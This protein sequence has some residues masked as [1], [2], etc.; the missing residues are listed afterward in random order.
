VVA[1]C[2]EDPR[3]KSRE[4]SH[5]APRTLA[6]V[7]SDHVAFK[8]ECIDRVY[9]NVYVPQLQH[10]GEGR[11]EHRDAL[12][13]MNEWAASNTTLCT[14]G[15]ILREYLAVA[16]RPASKNGLGLKPADAVSNVRAI[17]ERTAFLAED[18]KVADRLQNLLADVECGGNQAHDANVIATMIARGVGTVVTMNAA[19]FAHFERYVSLVEL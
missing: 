4:A 18:A 5:N 12:T 16:T 8:L 6:E 3:Q 17:R 13:I 11:A 2:S 14:S 10:A 15:Q 1:N 7:L 19:D 9:L